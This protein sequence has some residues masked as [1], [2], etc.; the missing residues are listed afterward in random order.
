MTDGYPF[1][2]Y[3]VAPNDWSE[4]ANDGHVYDVT[5]RE[6]PTGAV[7]L[8]LAR[9]WEAA[10]AAG[11]ARAARGEPWR[12][13]GR[14]ARFL[15]GER[16]RGADAFFGA[17]RTM[18][19]ALHAAWSI[20]EAVFRGSRYGDGEVPWGRD[21]WDRW[22]VDQQT[23]PS[24]AVSAGTVDPAFE[25]A[26]RIAVHGEAAV[27]AAEAAEAARLAEGAL[28]V[29][30]RTGPA[31]TYPVPPGAAAALGA[32]FPHD[33]LGSPSGRV[34]LRPSSIK[35]PI[36]WLGD[37]GTAMR[38]Q[39]GEIASG[40]VVSSDGAHI[41][42]ASPGP[43]ARDRVGHEVTLVALRDGSARPVWRAQ[44]DDPSVRGLWV[45][46]SRLAILTKHLRLF[47]LDADG[48]TLLDQH[49]EDNRAPAL[50]VGLHD[51]RVLVA[52]AQNRGLEAYRI[53][54][55]RI[56]PLG[57]VERPYRFKPWPLPATD[58]R[59]LVGVSDPKQEPIELVNLEARW[60]AIF[61]EPL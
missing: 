57:A 4:G 54:R 55:G 14:R 40:P 22:S 29:V 8:E 2:F 3:G 58:G 27:L 33:V 42:V 52:I 17:A 43:V 21:A 15:L 37:D 36:V 6:P 53:D 32:R 1:R 11:P 34:Y 60:Q 45:G 16:E 25:R 30:P 47:A 61:G 26:R 59:R 39:G 38:W 18:M 12:W 28:A 44:P 51:E 31:I 46:R 48:V 5:F 35:D 20:E 56:E 13:S 10:L 7:K 50:L 24:A 23:E 49:G 19:E 41:A 9:R